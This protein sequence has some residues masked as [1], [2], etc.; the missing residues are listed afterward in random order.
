MDNSIKNQL[1]IERYQRRKK[2]KYD[3][4]NFLFSVNW[5]DKYPNCFVVYEHEII[6]FK[7]LMTETYLRLRLPECQFYLNLNLL[8]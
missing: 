6:Q 7:K 4:T 5:Y 2:F 3:L 1:K 8:K